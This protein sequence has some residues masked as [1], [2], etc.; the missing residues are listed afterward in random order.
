MSS[1]LIVNPRA[2]RVTP[3]LTVAVERALAA[4]GEVE[5]LITEGPRHAADLA[6]AAADA[7]E[8][9]YVFGGDGAFNEVVN[10][11]DNADLP[12]GF[13]PGGGTSVLS[14]ALGLPRDPV[15]C[16]A[17]IAAA[18]RERR[19]SLGRVNG[20]RFTFSAGLGL[21][22]ELI[23]RVDD[24]G[25]QY[26]KRP[27]DV[28][29][30][31]ALAGILAGRRGRLRPA[32]TVA[33]HGRVAFALVANCDPYTYVGAIPVHAAPL[34]RF[35]L[36]LD[37]VAPRAVAPWQLPRLAAWAFGGRG[38]VSSSRALYLHDLDELEIECDSPL[39]LQVDG[40]DLGDVDAARFEAEREAL[41]VLVG[42]T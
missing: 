34:A 38:Q 19:I 5:T 13:V 36:G 9:I 20:R 15:A 24:R 27:G 37:L 39:P 21:D 41:R 26:G 11:L 33:G 17:A 40:E 4:G 42:D 10:G 30:V 12:V 32:M 29:F 23:R 2:S 6:A 3:E 31:R 7:Y 28:V 8:R 25:R 22:A 35:D 1:A 18:T 14:R 16:A